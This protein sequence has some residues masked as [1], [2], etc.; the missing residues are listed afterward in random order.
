MSLLRRVGAAVAAALAA[1]GVIDESRLRATT[2]LA[3][4]RIVTGFAIMSKRT[5]DLALVGLVIGPTAVA[6]LTLA[7]AFWMAAKFVAIGLAG[8]TVALVS[9]NYG[10]GDDERAAAVVRLSVLIALALA[11]P[12]VAAFGLAAEPLVGLLGGDET[13]IGYG[14]TYLAVVAP[15]L[16]FEF[17]NL[18][19]SRTYAGVSDT[20]T[21]MVVRAGGG[22]ANIALS[23]TFVLGF[24]MGVAGAA[25]GTALATGLVTVVFAWGMTG[26]SYLRGRGASPVPLRLRG[27]PHDRELLTQIGRVSAPLVARRAAQGLVVFPL[28]A[29]AATFGPVAVAAVGVGRQVRALLGSFSWGFSIAASTLVGQEL[30]RGDESEAEAYGRGITRLSLLVYLVAAAVVVALAEPI[31]AVFVDDPAN[32]ALSADFVRVAAISVVALGVDGSITG[33]LRGAGD[34]RVPFVATL[35]G[36]YL[37]ALPLAWA[38]TVIPAL[39]VGGLLLSLLAE[40]AVP[41][42]VNLRRFRSNRWKAVSRS[43]R[44][45]PGD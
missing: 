11:V 9:Q 34:T 41:L 7:N 14:A 26:R 12:A 24:D 45:S 16:L 28:L 17:L 22:I 38:G 1:A 29:I 8:G 27:S 4:P 35:A 39:G 6:G 25:L 36:A 18:I 19:A 42:A 15:G 20:V 2:D 31:A 5:V 40:T 43:Y 13:A 44:P 21:P 32:L 10:G 3:W 37:A 30:G 23:A 33:T